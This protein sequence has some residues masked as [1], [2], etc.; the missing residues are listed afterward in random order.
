MREGKLSLN[1]LDIAGKR[2]HGW[3][4]R[5]KGRGIYYDPPL[6]WTRI[7]LKVKDQYE[8]GDNTWIGMHNILGEWCLALHG[9][10]SGQSSDRSS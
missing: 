1:Q 3:G 8:S 7:R 5:E 4:V 2:N 10:G 6:G 9:V